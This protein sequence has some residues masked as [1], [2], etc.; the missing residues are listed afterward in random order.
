MRRLATPSVRDVV[1]AAM[2]EAGPAIDEWAAWQ[3]Y[4]RRHPDRRYAVA[5]RGTFPPGRLRRHR[6][7]QRA[8]RRCVSRH[9]PSSSMN[10]RTRQTERLSLSP[11]HET[12]SRG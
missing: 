1:T 6:I 11:D 3:D 12:R 2:I 5:K 8:R 7:E 10:E 4:R 9:F